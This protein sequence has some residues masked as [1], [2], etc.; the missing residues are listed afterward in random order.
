MFYRCSGLES[1]NIPDNITKIGQNT[2]AK[3]DAL[4][5]VTLP[6]TL[7][8]IG[9]N[10]FVNC[11]S[12]ENITIPKSVS[13]IEEGAFGYD[14]VEDTL[15]RTMSSPLLA[16]LSARHT[17]TLMQM[18]F[19]SFLWIRLSPQ[20]PPQHR[21]L[22]RKPHKLLKP[23]KCRLLVP[24]KPLHPQTQ[25]PAVLT[26]LLLP[27]TAPPKQ[28]PPSQFRSPFCTATLIWMAELV[29]TMPLC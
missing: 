10:A 21:L 8:S 17:I 11:G 25:A 15:Q 20:I 13:T 12:L 16:T 22:L 23:Q 19:R 24:M 27:L 26:K 7:T 29:W 28:L 14:V 4:K 18:T 6:D 9:K 2:F 5:D 3:C 1:I